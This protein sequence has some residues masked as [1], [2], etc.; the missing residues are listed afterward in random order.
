MDLKLWGPSTGETK[1]T[2]CTH[3]SSSISLHLSLSAHPSFSLHSTLGLTFRHPDIT[4]RFWLGQQPRLRWLWHLTEIL[5]FLIYLEVFFSGIVCEI[6]RQYMW[7]GS[8]ICESEWF[9]T[10]V[11]MGF[12]LVKLVMSDTDF[13]TSL[14]TGF[15]W[16]GFFVSYLQSDTTQKDTVNKIRVKPPW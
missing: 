9:L 10:A 6:C 7:L 5:L 12:W 8:F 16:T 13:P 11:N 2:S 4:G 14:I 1:G 15:V 3:F